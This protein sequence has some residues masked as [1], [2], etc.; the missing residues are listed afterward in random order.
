M[1]GLTDLGWE[2][3]NLARIAT[4]R[5]STSN[6]VPI[7]ARSA[8]LFPTESVVCLIMTYE[9]L[10]QP[11]CTWRLW[12]MPRHLTIVT[13]TSVKVRL[14]LTL[15]ES[16]PCW[17]LPSAR[18]APSSSPISWKRSRL[19]KEKVEKRNARK[20]E[21]SPCLRKHTEKS[22]RGVLRKERVVED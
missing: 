6:A 22:C 3:R 16:R 10:L 18:S 4:V 8:A 2:K 9:D 14:L 7:S 1:T 20:R 11:S 5:G 19:W 21:N 12:H 15:N 17:R 13:A